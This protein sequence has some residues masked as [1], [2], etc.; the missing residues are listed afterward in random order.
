MIKT[1]TT[2]WLPF[3]LALLLASTGCSQ[4]P[5][6]GVESDAGQAKH[7]AS[8]HSMTVPKD[9]ETPL[10]Q[11]QQDLAERAGV[12]LQDI[13]L[14]ETQHV[15]WPSGALGCPEPGMMYTQALVPGYRMTLIA[16]G[17]SYLYHGAR[18]RAPF[19]CPPE[20]ATSPL[21]ADDQELR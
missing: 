18:G 5:Q 17:Q 2:T 8:E 9:L 10:A 21:P 3:V 20:R 4:Q 14:T 13:E 16:D 6:Q 15:T 7:S 12:A 19:Y 11:A 1:F